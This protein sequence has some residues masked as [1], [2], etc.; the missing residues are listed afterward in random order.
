[1]LLKQ[2]LQVLHPYH[3]L[4]DAQDNFVGRLSSWET[5]SRRTVNNHLAILGDVQG[6]PSRCILLLC[7]IYARGCPVAILHIL[8]LHNDR[9]FVEGRLDFDSREWLKALYVVKQHAHSLWP[10][11]KVLGQGIVTPKMR[12]RDFV[13]RL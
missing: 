12:Y 3:L 6:G 2:Q 9:S 8:L 7:R 11:R 1:M 13:L 4:V 10:C 5:R